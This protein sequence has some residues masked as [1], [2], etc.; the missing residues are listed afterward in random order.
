LRQD[1]GASHEL[2]IGNR[3]HLPLSGKEPV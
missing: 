2:F 1:K 3:E